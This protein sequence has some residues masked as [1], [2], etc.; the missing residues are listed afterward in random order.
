MVTDSCVLSCLLCCVC[1]DEQSRQSSTVTESPP[2]PQCV[3]SLFVS[4]MAP[5][6]QKV[7]AF[8]KS[9][10]GEQQFMF[11]ML[12]LNLQIVNLQIV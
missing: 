12:K 8:T 1:I 9:L 11:C 7:V 3:W 4:N 5:V 2:D 10:P 6:I